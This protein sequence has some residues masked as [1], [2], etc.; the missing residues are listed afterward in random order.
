MPNGGQ[1]HDDDLHQPGGRE[2]APGN[3]RLV[4][5][6][7]NSNYDLVEN[8]GA[9]LLDSPEALTRWLERRGL[10][11][12]TASADDL[13]RALEIRE[14][15]R[16]LLIAKHDGDY[17]TLEQTIEVKLK[18]TA[19]TATFEPANDALDLILAQAAAAQ[20][21]GSWAR[22]K[23]CR[24]CAWAFYDRSRNGAGNW[25][26]MNVCGGRAKQRAH[27]RRTRRS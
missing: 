23:A 5:A 2:P 7:I 18:L 6:F 19:T 25:C 8:H 21:D 3:L 15:L 12:T 13:E 11:A 24:E 17:A 4:Q 27:Y 22:L 16:A 10:K 1:A 20:L 9:E 26:S 14:A